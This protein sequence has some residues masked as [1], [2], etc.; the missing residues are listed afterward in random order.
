MF[1][2]YAKE[3]ESLDSTSILALR[4]SSRGY[5]ELQ[6]EKAHR[7]GH[8]EPDVAKQVHEELTSYGNVNAETIVRSHD[9]GVAVTM[10]HPL[11]LL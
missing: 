4:V 7:R 10:V 11:G 9:E 2:V 6:H 3:F 5:G 1:S 8:R